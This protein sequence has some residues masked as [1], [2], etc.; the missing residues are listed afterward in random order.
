MKKGNM[1]SR[2]YMQSS[3]R[4]S[5]LLPYSTLTDI[6]FQFLLDA[7]SRNSRSYIRYTVWENRLLL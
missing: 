6:Y 2:K 7:L 3:D 1:K 5:Q 4:E